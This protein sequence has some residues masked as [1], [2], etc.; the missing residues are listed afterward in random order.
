MQLTVSPQNFLG[1]SLGPARIGRNPNLQPPFSG[2]PTSEGN[3]MAKLPH[4]T[5]TQFIFSYFEIMDIAILGA[6]IFL[7]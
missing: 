1:R 2:Y 4:W 5:P 6:N 7:V 3:V